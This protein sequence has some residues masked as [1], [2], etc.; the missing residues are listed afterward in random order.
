LEERLDEKSVAVQEAKS[1]YQDLAS[2]FRSIRG[3][4]RTLKLYFAKFE[5]TIDGSVQEMFEK[6]VEQ[7]G[8]DFLAMLENLDWVYDDLRL[9]QQEVVPCMPP[10]WNIFEVYVKHIHKRVYD[11]VKNIVASE[12]DAATIIKI[13]EWIKTYKSTMNREM[14]IAETKLTPPL[15]DGKEGVLIDDY[16]HIIIRKVEE[17]MDSLGNTEKKE[18]MERTTSPD[19]DSDGKYVSGGAAIMFQM[20]S[21]QIDVAANSGQGRVLAAVVEECV[22]VIKNRQTMWTDLLQS[23]VK[24]QIETPE[25]VP[26]GFLDYTIAL[27]N[28]QILCADYTEAILGRTEPLVSSKYKAKITNG[29]N[30]SIDGFLDLAKFA[31]TIIIQII[32]NDLKPVL[33]PIFTS[34]WYG[35]TDVSRIVATLKDYTEDLQAHMNDYLFETLME[36]LLVQFITA[37]M[38]AAKAKSTKFKMSEAIG[39]IRNDVKLAYG[40]FSQYIAGD[41]VQEYFRIFEFL[42]TLLSATKQTFSEDLDEWMSVYWD[43]P[44]WYRPPKLLLV[45]TGSRFVEAMINNRD[46]LDRASAKELLALLRARPKEMA[47]DREPTYMSKLKK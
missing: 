1:H 45:L 39:Q 27:A 8:E 9:L 12:P 47:G 40:Y 32:F 3:S 21:Q 35:G 2:K 25:E 11:T 23:E 6:H 46:D 22:H 15:L 10:K 13:L 31:V 19:E 14:G 5:E 18:F 33:N 28:D 41:I 17:W 24:R 20:I 34:S 42:M 36:D 38:S 30:Q 7:Y 29:F 37:Y 4:P 16:L 44:V 43:T 26:V